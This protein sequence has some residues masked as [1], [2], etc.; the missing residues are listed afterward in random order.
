MKVYANNLEAIEAAVKII[1][2]ITDEPELNKIYTGK[3][4]KVVDF[5]AF[6]TFMTGKDGLVHISELADHHVKQVTDIC[7][8]G[9]EVKVQLIGFDRGKVAFNEAC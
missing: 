8:E 5:G 7:N 4:A 6:V 2:D 3:V 9:D 1:K